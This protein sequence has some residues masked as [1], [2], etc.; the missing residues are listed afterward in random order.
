MKKFIF[1]ALF[2][3]CTV[4]LN[5]ISLD[6]VTEVKKHGSVNGVEAYSTE[7]PDN[8]E[9]TYCS[10]FYIFDGLE[11]TDVKIVGKTIVA[12][13]PKSELH[14]LLFSLGAK[15]IKTENSAKFIVDM[16]SPRLNTVNPISVNNQFV[17]MQVCVSGNTVQIGIPS[18]CGFI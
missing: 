9:S 11:K 13:I 14:K 1:V 12:T 10:P 18:L 17:N 15:T 2:V 6:L 8:V 16:Y 5:I 7:K 4:L 3:V